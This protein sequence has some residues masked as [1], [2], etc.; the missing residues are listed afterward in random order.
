MRAARELRD[1]TTEDL[2]DVLR[3]DDETRQLTLDENRGRCL[4]TGSLDPEDDV[5]HGA[6]FRGG[7][8]SPNREWR[9]R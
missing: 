4:I 7:A 3:E 8:G 2:V 5:S 9:A 1:D 6:A